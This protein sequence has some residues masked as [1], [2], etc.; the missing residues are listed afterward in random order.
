MDDNAQDNCFRNVT[1]VDAQLLRNIVTLLN[2]SQEDLME[3]RKRFDDDT[4]LSSFFSTRENNNKTYSNIISKCEHCS[5]SPES[6]DKKASSN[7]QNNEK[8]NI[9][10]TIK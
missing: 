6:S 2:M 9:I 5:K 1:H 8:Y 4:P 10:F 7:D 3:I